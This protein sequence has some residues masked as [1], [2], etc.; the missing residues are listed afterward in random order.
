LDKQQAPAA[1]LRAFAHLLLASSI[2]PKLKKDVTTDRLFRN[3]LSAAGQCLQA[4]LLDLGQQI[5]EN[6]IITQSCVDDKQDVDAHSQEQQSCMAEYYCLRLLLAWKRDRKDLADHWYSKISPTVSGLGDSDV[7]KIVDLLHELGSDC[8]TQNDPHGAV[9]WLS[10][11]LMLLDDERFSASFIRS[12]LKLTVLHYYVQALSKSSGKDAQVQVESIIIQ[13]MTEYGTKLPVT[14]LSLEVICQSENADPALIAPLLQEIINTAHV[15]ESN[16]RL[17]LHFTHYLHKRNAYLA[18]QCLKSY[19]VNRLMKDG[20]VEWVENAIISHLAMVCGTRNETSITTVKDLEN[21]LGHYFT[22]TQSSISVRASQAAHVLIWK[23]VH[24]AESGGH[25][26][27]AMS[28]CQLGLHPLF[29]LAGEINIGKLE[30]KLVCYHLLVSNLSV[31]HRMLEDMSFVRRNN[32]NSRYLAYCVAVRSGNE[33]EAQSCLNTI[34]NGQGE[35]DQL[36]FACAG[37]SIQYGEPIDVARVLQR[38]FDK[39][40]QSPGPSIDLGVLLKCTAQSLMQSIAKGGDDK[41]IDEEIILRFCTV[42]KHAAKLHNP[43][44]AG[45]NATR[46]TKVDVSWFE[47]QAF[48]AAKAH[49]K[50]W[51]KRYL[52]D[53][54]QYSSQLGGTKSDFPGK[55]MSSEQRRTRT[56]DNKFMQAVLYA[57]E[58]RNVGSNYTVEDLPRTSYDVKSKPKTSE[59]RVVLYQ[60]V[61]NNFSALY[62][63]YNTS[64]IYTKDDELHDT[65]DQVHLLVPL[66]FEAIL[67]MKA[68]EYLSAEKLAFD[69]AS[70][71]NLL[72]IANELKVTAATYALLADIV[73][74]FANDGAAMSTSLNGLQIPSISAARLLGRIIQALREIQ[75]CNIDEAAR[76]I[77]CVVQLIIDGIEKSIILQKL[78]LDDRQKSHQGLQMLNTVIQQAIEL[79]RSSLQIPSPGSDI[80][81]TGVE[82]TFLSRTYPQEELEWLATKLFNMAIDFCSVEQ[83]KIARQWAMKAIELADLVKPEE[84]DSHPADQGLASVLRERVDQLGWKE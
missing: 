7:E 28:W 18:I 35:D 39:H 77:R 23:M 30:R 41:Q 12:D 58:A 53:V 15:I 31:A 45:R 78:Q 22:N 11:A 79:A 29:E 74:A 20:T 72:H 80:E 37:E 1:C 61:F 49:L 24:E 36:L 43:D 5:L 40:Y 64:K 70:T 14:L 17:I 63:Q 57:S 38:I 42:I 13:L 44:S 73:L 69:E 54:L 27:L 25:R 26:S 82:S 4:N 84:D 65:Q 10:R 71:L 75:A 52:I 6:E 50:S 19:I 56:R 8:L 67:F 9:R 81:M 62:E 2:R 3:A 16:H 51:P 59:C 66:A 47:K 33:A 55:G 32:G 76:W 21:D 34:I 68:D 60:N 83:E 46:T 48:E